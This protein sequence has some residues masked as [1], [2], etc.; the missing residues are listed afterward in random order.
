[1]KLRTRHFGEISIDESKKI[2]FKE[3]IPGFEHLKHFIMIEQEDSEFCYLQSLQDGDI[4][5]AV[6]HPHKITTDYTPKINESYFE[7]LGGGQSEDF[8]L[9]VITTVGKSLEETTINLQAPLLIHMN[10]RQ[11]V[12]AIVEGKAYHTKHKVTELLQNQEV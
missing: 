8:T 5:F 2:T 12:Q 9:Y 4:A 6:I 1:M 7:K 10:S 11:G 3:G